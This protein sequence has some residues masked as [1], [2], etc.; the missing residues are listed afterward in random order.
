[1]FVPAA[2]ERQDRAE[3][4]RRIDRESQQTPQQRSSAGSHGQMTQG[5][6]QTHRN[7]IDY[8]EV[9]ANGSVA[10]SSGA[11]LPQ[12]PATEETAAAPAK[13]AASMVGSNKSIVANR[14]ALRMANL[15]A[16][17]ML[18]AE[19]AGGTEASTPT[20][21]TTADE[22]DPELTKEKEAEEA[23]RAEAER[24]SA[25]AA[26]LRAELLAS[27]DTA[28]DGSPR[29]TKRNADTAV[30]EETDSGLD[31]EAGEDDSEDASVNAFLQDSLVPPKP[32]MVA[33]LNIEQPPPLKLM[34]NNV[35]E[36]DDAVK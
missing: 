5:G 12:K 31:P 15:S 22:T 3:K 9:N 25:A 34:G 17:D 8:V 24:N 1:M 2:E 23:G 32:A 6:G 10:A 18:K 28:N 4:R 21:E 19:L 33:G 27:D 13:S 16:A 14:M 29:G 36:Q 30:D 7:G 35:V 20:S 11:A 26:K